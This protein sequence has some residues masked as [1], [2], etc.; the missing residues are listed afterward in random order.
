[1][2]S[3]GARA[4]LSVR[5]Y[6]ILGRVPA[7]AR[8]RAGRPPPQRGALSPAPSLFTLH[9]APDR[10]KARAQPCWAQPEVSKSITSSSSKIASS[11]NPKTAHKARHEGA[12]R[13]LPALPLL[14]NKRLPVGE[15]GGAGCLLRAHL[16]HLLL[17]LQ[18]LLLV[19]HLQK[20][21]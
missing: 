18:R 9:A 16:L 11:C 8:R 2:I 12:S 14:R 10:A 13:A 15:G 21:K 3:A 7:R 19:V 17:L 5:V 20:R 6:S 4:G 1:M